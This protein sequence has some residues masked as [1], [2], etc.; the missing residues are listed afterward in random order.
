MRTIRL[1]IKEAGNIVT[2]HRIFS[3]I[4]LLLVEFS[5]YDNYLSVVLSL[6]CYTLL[7]NID[8]DACLIIDKNYESLLLH[9]ENH[10]S[11]IEHSIRNVHTLLWS[12]NNKWLLTEQHSKILARL[13]TSANYRRT[14]SNGCRLVRRL[15]SAERVLVHAQWLR[16]LGKNQLRRSKFRN[17]SGRNYHI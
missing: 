17:D 2:N 7:H 11:L 1:P 14:F 6:F 10:N 4:K 5:V 8:L 13:V 3:N 16:A 9:L 15:L 12:G